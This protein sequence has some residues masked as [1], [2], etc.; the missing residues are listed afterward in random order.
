MKKLNEY[1]EKDLLRLTGSP[2]QLYSVKKYMLEDGKGKGS[3]IYQVTTGGK[4][5]FDLAVDNAMDLTN[6]SYNGVNI[7][8][9]SKNGSVVSSVNVTGNTTI[10]GLWSGLKTG[11]S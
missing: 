1:N 5:Q 4:L 10:Y 7:S 11:K 6:L 9:I 8:Y 2:E 3:S